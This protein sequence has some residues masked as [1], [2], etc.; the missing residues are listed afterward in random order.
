MANP[1]LPPPPACPLSSCG[2]AMDLLPDGERYACLP[3]GVLQD[4]SPL[5]EDSNKLADMEQE[6]YTYSIVIQELMFHRRTIRRLE[7]EWKWIVAILFV[8]IVNLALD[9]L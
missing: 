4:G 8:L 5:R 2:L 9:F 6:P 1:P 7:R 3:C